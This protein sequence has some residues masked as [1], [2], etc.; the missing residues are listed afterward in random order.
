MKGI[1]K[2]M[3]NITKYDDDAAR[4]LRDPVLWAEKHLKQKPRWYQEQ[5]LRHPH[6][7]IVLRC[8][9]RLGKCIAGSQR[10]LNVDTGAYETIESLYKKQIKETPV[11]SLQEDYK[12]ERTNTFFIE[13]NGMKPTFAVRTKHGAQVELTG[14]HP[15]LTIDG[16]KEVDALKVGESIAV[17]KSLPAFGKN[18]PSKERIKM[19]GYI[20]AGYQ[21][22]KKGPMLSFYS[23]EPVLEAIEYSKNVGITLIKR[24]EQNY[25]FYDDKEN[26]KDVIKER[27]VGIPKEV[28]EY[29][30][31][32]LKLF[33]ASFYDTNS[34][35]YSERVA[36]IGYGS[37]N[38]QL[39]RDLKHLLLRFGIDANI[40]EREVNGM[41]YFQLM[42]HAKKEVL[43][44][45]DQIGIYSK[46][47]YSKTKQHALTMNEK[48]ATIPKEI[49]S[50]VEK[51][52][53]LKNMMKYEVTG[54]RNEKF[55]YNV[56]LSEEKAKR[57]GENLQSTFLYDLARS[58]IYW[59]EVTHITPLGE[60]QTYDV[61][62]PEVH[63]L[64][65]EDILVHNT[66]TMAAHML[67]VIFTNNGGK[68]ETGGATCVVATPYDNQA[69]LI[70]DQLCSFIDE[71]E[72]LTNSLKN[73]T[74]S[75]YHIEFNNGGKIKLFTAGT[76]SGQ[77]GASLRGQKADYLYM[78]KIT[79]SLYTAKCIEEL[80]EFMGT[81]KGENVN[82][83]GRK[84]TIL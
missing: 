30:K 75:P 62:V 9:R 38:H 55:R 53:K 77:G 57:Y 8:G 71:S 65:V 6:N 45:I 44:F 61:F 27:V 47:D 82:E 63:N 41:E 19:V 56:G 37:K 66:W 14:N 60:Q 42:I 51:E 50:Y 13:D 40:V 54:S 36:E 20:S 10:M 25:F 74:K 7:R 31:E 72:L 23:Q 34:W 73:R 80:C 64:V 3:S 24:S 83:S 22:S 11:F 17:P 2:H 26:F 16:W 15:V 12:L 59:E 29:D 67:W 69:K 32:S 49:W 4:I 58:D 46:K 43:S 76:K 78:D 84:R 70:Y 21:E 81:L 39:V 35:S 33:L 52:R 5:I 28:F 68:I 1:V 18:K 79:L 48:Q